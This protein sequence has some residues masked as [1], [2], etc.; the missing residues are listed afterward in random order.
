[1]LA[2]HRETLFTRISAEQRRRTCEKAI[3]LGLDVCDL[4]VHAGHK[5]GCS[6]NQRNQLRIVLCIKGLELGSVRNR[7]V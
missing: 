1:M 2:R 3:A 6:A 5:R 7:S 4:R